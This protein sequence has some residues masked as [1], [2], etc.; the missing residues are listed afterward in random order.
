MTRIWEIWPDIF[1][2][3]TRHLWQEYDKYGMTYFL[4]WQDIYDKNMIWHI[5]WN[6]KRF[7]TRIWEIWHDIFLEIF[8]ELYFNWMVTFY[9]TMGSYFQTIKKMNP[10]IN[11][12]W[13]L[14]NIIYSIFAELNLK[15]NYIY[16]IGLVP[17]QSEKFNQNLV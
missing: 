12:Y 3:M 13:I 16:P 14:L 9:K 15:C 8:S 4:K 17:I 5:S 6:D 1:L 10:P 11:L 7:M 2:E